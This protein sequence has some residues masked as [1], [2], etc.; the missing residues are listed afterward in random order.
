MTLHA[1][2]NMFCKQVN[3]YYEF[4]RRSFDFYFGIFMCFVPFYIQQR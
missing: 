2:K 3:K 4:T 1:Q